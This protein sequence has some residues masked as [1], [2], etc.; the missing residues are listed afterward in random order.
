MDVLDPMV[1]RGV[2]ETDGI[3]RSHAQDRQLQSRL[4][5]RA[6]DRSAYAHRITLREALSGAGGQQGGSR[7]TRRSGPYE[8]TPVWLFAILH[9]EFAPISGCRMSTSGLSR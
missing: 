9:G 4:S 3:D 1:E 7:D 6:D 5:Q 2:H 8:L